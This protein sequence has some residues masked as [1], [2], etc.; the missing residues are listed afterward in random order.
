MIPHMSAHK[1]NPCES[2]LADVA[3]IGLFTRVHSTMNLQAGAARESP[4]TYFALVRFLS[5]VRPS[6]RPTVFG[7]DKALTTLPALMG[8]VAA[9][10]PRMD[11]QMTHLTEGLSAN[12]A[13]K[14]FDLCMYKLVLIQVILVVETARADVARIGLLTYKSKSELEMIRRAVLRSVRLAA[15]TYH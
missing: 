14:R 6:M 1:L 15:L 13:V 3:F 12:R 7:C 10:R 4:T 11:V 5:G 9:V 8:L 2:H